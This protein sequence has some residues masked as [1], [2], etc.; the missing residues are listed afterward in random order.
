MLNM[1][2]FGHKSYSQANCMRETLFVIN[3]TVPPYIG[4]LKYKS[5]SQANVN[6]I[7]SPVVSIR[8]MRG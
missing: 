3:I 4:T 2:H 1:F 7:N 6:W 8:K 5:Y